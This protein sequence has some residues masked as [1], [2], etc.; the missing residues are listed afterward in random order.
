MAKLALLALA[1][2]IATT[3]F[4]LFFPFLHSE[5]ILDDGHK[6]V[7]NYDLRDWSLLPWSLFPQYEKG[8][9]DLSL[10]FKM[11][12]NDPS[13][14]LTFLMYTLE[15]TVAGGAHPWIFRIVNITLHGINSILLYSLLNLLR[16]RLSAQ[17]NS[18]NGSLFFHAAATIL[19]AFCPLNVSTVNYAYGRS[20]ILGFTFELCCFQFLLRGQNRHLAVGFTSLLAMFAKQSYICIVPCVLILFLFFPSLSAYPFPS[21]TDFRLRSPL[22]L[23][24]RAFLSFCHSMPCIFAAAFCML[25]R[26]IYL[27]GLGDLEAD[28]SN[29]PV[30]FFHYLRTQPYAIFSYL[31]ISCSGGV[32]VDHGVLV[33]DPVPILY[34]CF[35]IGS[36]CVATCAVCGGSLLKLKVVLFGW[37][38]ALAHLAPTSLIVTTDVMADRRFYAASFPFLLFVCDLVYFLRFKTNESVSER[39][40]SL[41]YSNC[42]S[43]H[44]GMFGAFGI[45]LSFY[46]ALAYHHLDAYQSNISAWRSVLDLYPNSVRAHNNLATALIQK[47]RSCPPGDPYALLSVI[48]YFFIPFLVLDSNASVRRAQPHSFRRLWFISSGSFTEIRV[49]M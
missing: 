1:I 4:T 8:E 29:Q 17:N 43:A 19:W 46:L 9:R 5:F 30:P 16:E 20:E 18:S 47:C 45:A 36:L 15:Y 33:D 35:M 34:P 2:F 26:L 48:F 7:E 3:L 40:F 31:L 37:V 23:Y 39:T 27:G 32:S 44:V 38:F 14:P 10:Q 11:N 42:F 12:R 25:Y 13:R 49:I 28:P 21:G 6:I 24:A 41:K 22:S